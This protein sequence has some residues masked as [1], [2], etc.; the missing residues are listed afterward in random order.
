MRDG[1]MLTKHG[2]RG[3]PHKRLLY[4]CSDAGARGHDGA[5]V[6]F[7][8]SAP[9]G[10]S[11]SIGAT[12]QQVHRFADVKG[13]RSALEAD[14]HLAGCVGQD[15][16]PRAPRRTAVATRTHP[17]R[18]PRNYNYCPAP[19]PFSVKHGPP[20]ADR[21]PTCDPPSSPAVV[22]RPSS[23]AQVR[24]LQSTSRIAPADSRDQGV[25]D[26][27]AGMD[28]GRR[29]TDGSRVSG[30]R[31]GIMSQHTHTNGN[32][33]ALSC[34]A[35]VSPSSPLLPPV[36]RRCARVRACAR[37]RVPVLGLDAA[38]RARA[39]VGEPNRRLQR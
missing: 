20:T 21:L 30:P 8:W 29:R 37:A 14:P 13:I 2:R 17:A 23:P 9:E 10:Q 31:S 22:V 11:R 12:K 7:S 28:C 6:C 19:R 38:G 35:S 27:G 33:D 34:A 24:R 25:R 36:G 18:P 15:P 32:A 4:L 5:L 26:P 3:T 1:I 16:P 39:P